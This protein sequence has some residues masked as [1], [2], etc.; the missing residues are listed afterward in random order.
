MSSSSSYTSFFLIE[1]EHGKFFAGESTDPWKT[2]EEHREVIA[3]I[4]WTQIHRPVIL[5]EIVSVAE[6]ENVNEYVRQAMLQYGVE[7]VRGG[8]WSEPRLTD[9]D[10]Q[11]LSMELP[12]QRGCAV[13]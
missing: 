13:C 6:K 10:R 2:M 8:A 4:T 5:R 12:R 9:K 3:G 11:Q 7:N 1:L